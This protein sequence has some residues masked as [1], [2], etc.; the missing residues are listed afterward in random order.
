MP[1]KNSNSRLKIHRANAHFPTR[2]AAGEWM[3]NMVRTLLSKIFHKSQ[4]NWM[5]TL[6]IGSF[7]TILCSSKVLICQ[8]EAVLSLSRWLLYHMIASCTRSTCILHA[9]HKKRQ[10]KLSLTHWFQQNSENQRIS[11]LLYGDSNPRSP[12]P[13]A[14]KFRY[15]NETWSRIFIPEAKTT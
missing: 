5:A 3:A 10:S 14:A 11:L 2:E 6:V 13:Q 9:T 1:P 8:E 12:I 4:P 15:H 7:I